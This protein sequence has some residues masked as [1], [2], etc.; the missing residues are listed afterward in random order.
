MTLINAN[1][2]S[3]SF[4][5]SA[6]LLDNITLNIKLRERICIFGRNGSGK[7]TLIKLIKG[8][9]EPDAGTITRQKNLRI[10]ALDQNIPESIEGSIADILSQKLGK[11]S[12][13]IGS[14][15]VSHKVLQLT[16]QLN[17]NPSD[18]YNILSAGNKLR[19][20]F[21][22]ALINNPDILLLDEPTNHLDLSGINWL[23][24]LLISLNKTVLFVSHDRMFIKKIATRI[25]EIDIGNLLNW[26]CDYDT[27][28]IRKEA[29]LEADAKQR[30][31]FDKKLSSEEKWIRQG[32][33]A[34]RTRNQGRVRA[35]IK[36]R[37]LKQKERQRPKKASIKIQ[38]AESPGKIIFTV[39]NIS[40]NY[41]E[42]KVI[43][44]FS[45][46]IKRGDKVG[47]IGPNGSGKTT[48]IKILTGEITPDHGSVHTGTNLT[49]AYF[50]QHRTQL[51]YSKNVFDNIN[52]G[53]DTVIINNMSR[54][55]M[56]Y[57]SDFLFT[58]KRSLTPVKVISGGERN[59]LLLAKMFSQ[60]ANLL[61]LDEPTNDLDIPTLELLEELISE[62]P[63][64]VLLV[65]HDRTFLNNIATKTIVLDGTGK[66]TE[67]IGTCNTCFFPQKTSKK[68]KVS[69]KSKSK[70]ISNKLSFNDKRELE[71]LPEIIEKLEKEQT[72][73][74]N[75]LS[76][77]DFYKTKTDKIA[78]IK[79]RLKEIEK[80]IETG[81]AR[82]EILDRCMQNANLSNFCVK[83]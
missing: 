24:K 62:F 28:L 4:G 47:I 66:I 27:Y 37:N 25:I 44:S 43:D 59:R 69:K 46:I 52:D 60:P 13:L 23:E 2:I 12:N 79:N 8:T 11:Q 38:D 56:S 72:S 70:N 41:Q 26:S 16:S 3:I 10:E 68:I 82:W 71:K 67:H 49:I 42:K 81:Y 58:P 36:L 51:D 54:H 20:L 39:K 74:F 29:D 75:K 17:L 21:A 73:L 50:D 83:K 78:K 31:L 35:L 5:Q 33:K 77:P 9:I 7:S 19:V 34:R 53:N 6:P 45:T 63:G 30:A 64:T 80:K 76:E 57:L 18:K 15:D 32:I 55:V 65:S 48:L 40:L 22:K 61:I 14:Q 1:N